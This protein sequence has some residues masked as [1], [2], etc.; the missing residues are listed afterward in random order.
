MLSPRGCGTNGGKGCVFEETK[1]ENP[2][3]RPELN[4]KSGPAREMV[5][6]A[7]TAGACNAK[8][9]KGR[10]LFIR[11]IHLPRL[12]FVAG[13]FI[14]S[15]KGNPIKGWQKRCGDEDLRRNGR[16]KRKNSQNRSE[17]KADRG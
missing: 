10:R 9:V 12:F 3:P 17:F 2:P 4:S 1:I 16:K 14:M 11:V 13:M 8:K 5:R 7:V 6:L 15:G